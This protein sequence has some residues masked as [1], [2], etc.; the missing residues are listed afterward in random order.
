V[1]HVLSSLSNIEHIYLHLNIARIRDR[2]RQNET[3][4]AKNMKRLEAF[5]QEVEKVHTTFWCWW[6]EYPSEQRSI[7][8]KRVMDHLSYDVLYARDKPI[9]K[10]ELLQLM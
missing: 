10:H 3:F 6:K 8:E 5:K 4:A 1:T 7:A 9:I 2:L